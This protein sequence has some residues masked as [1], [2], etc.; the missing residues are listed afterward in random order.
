MTDVGG[1]G[2]VLEELGGSVGGR[3]WVRMRYHGFHKLCMTCLVLL[4]AECAIEA[5]VSLTCSSHRATSLRPNVMRMM[6][7]WKERK[8]YSGPFISELTAALNEKDEPGSATMAP[9]SMATD[10]QLDPG[11]SVRPADVYEVMCSQCQQHCTT[12]L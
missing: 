5:N 10:N 4:C 9:V 11:F 12:E 7:V 8:V 3:D 1:R 6:R 2:G